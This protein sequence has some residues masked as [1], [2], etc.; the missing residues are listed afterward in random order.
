MKLHA[1]TVGRSSSSSVARIL[2]PRTVPE[3]VLVED[4]TETYRKVDLQA[5]GSAD[6][7]VV[8]RVTDLEDTA[9]GDLTS[10]MLLA[11]MCILERGLTVRDKEQKIL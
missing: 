8:G 2:P 11:W 5:L 6:K 3:I 1:K 7:V 10:N 4:E 9:E